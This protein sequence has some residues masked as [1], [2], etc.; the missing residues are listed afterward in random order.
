MRQS[1][2]VISVGDSVIFD[3]CFS[4]DLR[5]LLEVKFGLLAREWHLVSDYFGLKKNIIVK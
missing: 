2:G 1:K 4:G 5:Q 3:F